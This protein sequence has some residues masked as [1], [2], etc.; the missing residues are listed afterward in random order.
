MWLYVLADKSNCKDGIY[1]D[2]GM[3]DG[4]ADPD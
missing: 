1:S 4:A 2:F 3:F